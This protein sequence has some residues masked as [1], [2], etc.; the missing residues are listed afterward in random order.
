[1]TFVRLG[2]AIVII[3]A[4][5]V[6]TACGGDSKDYVSPEPIVNTAQKTAAAGSARAAVDVAWT[7]SNGRHVELTGDGLVDIAGRR[8]RL[9]LDLSGVPGA[10]G[11]VEQIFDGSVVWMHIPG[12]ALPRGKKWIRID[13]DKASKDVGGDVGSFPQAASDPARVLTSMRSAAQVQDE[14]EEDVRGVPTTHYSAQV[15]EDVENLVELVGHP[16]LAAE[17]WVDD[18]GMIRR[19]LLKMPLQVP[20][21]G[22]VD[23]QFD[24][25][26]Y[27]FGVNVDVAPPPAEQVIEAAELLQHR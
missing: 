15:H 10:R 3:A 8:G 14:G 25:Q 17:A 24:Y 21:S 13:V 27:D 26:L 22:L 2:S 16:N 19:A 9:A 5:A 18:R 4:A 23:M 7:E 1:M 6:L 20:G 12:F 11:T